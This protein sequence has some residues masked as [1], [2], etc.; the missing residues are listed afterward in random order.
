MGYWSFENRNSY[1]ADQF[2]NLQ[3]YNSYFSNS[4]L[5]NS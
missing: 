4:Y 5:S 3:L 2:I 1:M